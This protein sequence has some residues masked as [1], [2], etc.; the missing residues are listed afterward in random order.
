MAAVFTTTRGHPIFSHHPSLLASVLGLVRCKGAHR[1]VG[2]GLAAA[3]G[4]MH[5]H[6]LRRAAMRAAT[7]A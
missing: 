4:E 2:L 3:A 5:R 6:V 1:G 7:R